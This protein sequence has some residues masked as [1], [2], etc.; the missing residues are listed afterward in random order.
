MFELTVSDEE[1]ERA[2]KYFD[3]HPD[4]FKFKKSKKKEEHSFVKIEGKIYVLANRFYEGEHKKGRLGKGGYGKVKIAQSRN[5][6]N[7]S[8]KIYEKPIHMADAIHVMKSQ[9]ILEGEGMRK[10]MR[11]SSRGYKKPSK[12]HYLLSKY[13]EGDSLHHYI[14][15]PER[16]NSLPLTPIEKYTI[17][18]KICYL[19]QQLHNDRVIHGDLKPENIIVKIDEKKISVDFIDFDFSFQLEIGEKTDRREARGSEGYMAPELNSYMTHFGYASDIYAIGK[20]FAMDF[21]FNDPSIFEDMIRESPEDRPLYLY[22]TMFKIASQLESLAHGAELDPDVVAIIEDAKKHKPHQDFLESLDAAGSIEKMADIIDNCQDE[23]ILT[24]FRE[25][26]TNNHEFAAALRAYDL[27]ELISSLHSSFFLAQHIQDSVCAWCTS[28]K[29]FYAMDIY[30]PITK[31]IL[32]EVGLAVAKKEAISDFQRKLSDADT[33]RDLLFA[34]KDASNDLKI[35]SSDGKELNREY[36]IQ[37]VQ[38]CLENKVRV[39][40]KSLL[41][42]LATEPISKE[43]NSLFMKFHITRTFGI[44]DKLIEVAKNQFREDLEQ[45]QQ[46]PRPK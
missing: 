2:Q 8:L 32:R 1:W 28:N 14:Y 34:L 46:K 40:G 12:K 21:R 20:I 43:I 33:F 26:G 3:E 18:L 35:L 36:M 29:L 15:N 22:N 39:G 38:H 44:R 24:Q 6:E 5:G 9:K 25:N 30:A 4:E 10:T 42:G 19:L 11:F 31:Y 16:I 41:E 13:I 45:R 37:F 23:I 27:N 17:A 7:Y